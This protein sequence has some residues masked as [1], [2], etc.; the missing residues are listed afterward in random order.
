MIASLAH[1]QMNLLDNLT[2]SA[3]D[4]TFIFIFLANVI[5]LKGQEESPAQESWETCLKG[6]SRMSLPKK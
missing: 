1:L 5:H 3:I 2:T 4:S 6:T